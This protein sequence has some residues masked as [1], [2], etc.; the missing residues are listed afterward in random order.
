M[1]ESDFFQDEEALATEE[2]S[3][4]ACDFSG[5]QEIYFRQRMREIRE[6]IAEEKRRPS[7]C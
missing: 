4:S 7:L 5:F 3:N 2:D 1:N 6:E